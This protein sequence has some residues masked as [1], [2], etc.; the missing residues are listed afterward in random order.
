MTFQHARRRREDVPGREAGQPGG[1]ARRATLRKKFVVER[2][3]AA[4]ISAS[5]SS[6]CLGQDRALVLGHGGLAEQKAR[7]ETKEDENFG[8]PRGRD[9]VS[10]RD[11]DQL[12]RSPDRLR[13]GSATV[14]ALGRRPTSDTDKPGRACD[15]EPEPGDAKHGR[16]G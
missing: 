5:V 16:R 1:H 15:Q 12:G 9:I 11:A 6:T 2:A 10:G 4:E 3:W 7:H 14:H 8:L 13:H